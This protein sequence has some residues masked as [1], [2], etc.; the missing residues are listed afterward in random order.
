MCHRHC[1]CLSNFEGEALSSSLP[2]SPTSEKSSDGLQPIA[3]AM[4]RMLRKETFRSPRSS[5]PIC[6]RSISAWSANASWDSPSASLRS[7]TAAPNR[8]RSLSLSSFGETLAMHQW[9]RY[10]ALTATAFTAH[11]ASFCI[12]FQLRPQSDLRRCW[13]HSAEV[14]KT[15]LRWQESSAKASTTCDPT[16]NNEQ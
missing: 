10:D 13:R 6:E 5:L 16:V 12:H 9:S 2:H 4:R 7:R 3:L 8:T 14:L 15:K 1:L 11:F